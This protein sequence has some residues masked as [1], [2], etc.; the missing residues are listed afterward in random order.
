MERRFPDNKRR[1]VDS[2]QM[3]GSPDD[4]Q[5]DDPTFI[6]RRAI[7]Y[8]NSSSRH[9]MSAPLDEIALQHLHR[10]SA[11]SVGSDPASAD[12]SKQR[13]PSR[14][15]II[16]AQRATT[17]ANQRAIL[18]TQANSVRGVDVLLP[19]NA[20]IRSSRYESGDKMRYSYV[21]PDGETYDISDIIEEE[22]RENNAANKQD[23]LEGVLV[24]NKDGLG[25]KIDRVLNKIKNGKANPRDKDLVQSRL[26]STNSSRQSASASE[27]SV[28][29]VAGAT[30]APNSRSVTPNSAGLNSR[31]PIPPLARGTS[32]DSSLPRSTSPAGMDDKNSRPGTLTPTAKPGPGARRHPSIASVLSDI[33]G[34][35]TPTTQ[36]A[37]LSP[38]ASPRSVT[39]KQKQ[40]LPFFTKDDFGLSHMLAIIEYRGSNPPA[41]L[42]VLDPVE[43]L[44]FGR[45]VDLEALHPQVREI[46]A[47]SFKQLDDMD[48]VC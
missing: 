29:D 40:K 30:E 26:G 22:W 21:Q 16:A 37:A 1:S 42:P 27:Y 39:P 10:E 31:T 3:L 33:S 4:V 15:E 28:D 7:S 24:R 2:G 14:Q 47:D 32:P 25:E 36:L 5:P 6:L 41:S 20:M 11:S 45:P 19:G 23:L 8:R 38:A 48:K 13:Q 34:Y 46:Y 18:S 9:R 43:K 35:A 17:R 12:D 44:L